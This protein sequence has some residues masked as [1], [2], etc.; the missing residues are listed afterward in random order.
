[1]LDHKRKCPVCDSAYTLFVQSVLGRRTGDLIPQFCCLDCR[2][3]FNPSGYKES[4]ERQALD[5]EYLSSQSDPHI[6]ILHQ[7]ALEIKT[8]VQHAKTYCEIG[9]GAGYLMQGMSNYGLDVYG[10]EVNPYC[11]QHASGTLGLPCENGLFDESHDRT[12]DLIASCMVFE[13]L[14]R[15][16]DLFAAMKSR[17]NA[18]GAIYISVPFIHRTD[19]PYLW[20]AERSPG[21]CPPDIFYDND[22]HITHFSVDGMKMMGQQFGARSSEYWVSTD[23]YYKSPGSYHGVLFRF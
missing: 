9:F 4:I 17:L 6:A 10:F 23:V 19:W 11:Y 7:L 20:S 3:F 14:E 22:V 13:H 15:P 8:R 2:S 5:F 12:Y 18:D 21:D 16:R 1:M